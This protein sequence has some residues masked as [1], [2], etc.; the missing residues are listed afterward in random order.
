MTKKYC[1]SFFNKLLIF[2][3][4]FEGL[5]HHLPGFVFHKNFYLALS[6]FQPRIADTGKLYSLLEQFE[7]LFEG[8]FA[9]LELRDDLFKP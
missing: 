6:F 5:R 7:R 9:A 2:L 8:Q 3:L 1:K 4:F